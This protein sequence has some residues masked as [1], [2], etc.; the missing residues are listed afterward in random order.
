[1]PNSLF[2]LVTVKLIIVSACYSQFIWSLI[3]QCRI[4]SSPPPA[5]WRK[6]WEGYIRAEQV[7]GD[8][9]QELPWSTTD[10]SIIS[11]GCC[12]PFLMDNAET[13]IYSCCHLELYSLS[14][15][16]RIFSGLLY[17]SATITILPRSICH[18]HSVSHALLVKPRA[19][20][21][22][23]CPN[24]HTILY[25]PYFLSFMVVQRMF[26]CPPYTSPEESGTHKS[27]NAQTCLEVLMPL[28]SIGSP[29]GS[30][31]PPT[32]GKPT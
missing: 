12:Y 27:T 14:P 23:S 13:F 9:V 17:L 18:S 16:V 11:S 26:S 31:M 22:G 24:P 1:M 19:A 28:P 25:L 10:M 6:R 4:S 8:G 32:F 21:S 29:S 5:L 3:N 7:G 20:I 2:D 30:R 15:R